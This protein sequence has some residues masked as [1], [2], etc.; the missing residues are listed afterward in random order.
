MSVPDL[1][2]SFPSAGRACGPVRAVVGWDRGIRYLASCAAGRPE[3]AP[4]PHG[5]APSRPPLRRHRLPSAVAGAATWRPPTQSLCRRRRAWPPGPRRGLAGQPSTQQAWRRQGWLS[6]R[7]SPAQ[8]PQ[9]AGAP[10][11][12]NASARCGTPGRSGSRA[13][14]H[15]TPALAKWPSQRT[16]KRRGCAHGRGDG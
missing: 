9:A 10:T 4:R 16:D 5:C 13:T 3:S 12:P 11:P 1:A 7:A 2:Q 8:P 14:P 6:G 15:G